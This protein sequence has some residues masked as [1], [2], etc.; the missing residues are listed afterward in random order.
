M[1]ETSYS[2]DFG[3]QVAASGPTV[4]GSRV[5]IA[6]PARDPSKQ[7]TTAQ[8]ADPTSYYYLSIDGPGCFI[9]LTDTTG[10]VI[11]PAG[12]WGPLRLVPGSTMY[13]EAASGSGTA[14]IIRA[15]AA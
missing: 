3:Q 1:R 14:G 10:A 5:K 12:F 11:V 9:A 13:V 2:P 4:S 15:R 6:V 7:F 8:S